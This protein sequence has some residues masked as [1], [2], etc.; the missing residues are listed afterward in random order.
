MLRRSWRAR[1]PPASASSWTCATSSA[2]QRV[3]RLRRTDDGRW[4]GR[5]GDAYMTWVGAEA[6]EPIA[7]GHGGQPLVMDLELEAGTSHDLVLLLDTDPDGEPPGCRSRLERDR[8][9]V[10]RALAR[11]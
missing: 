9:R 2:L 6:A 4:T 7:D 10:G 11:A 8:G 5:V 3:K 1:G